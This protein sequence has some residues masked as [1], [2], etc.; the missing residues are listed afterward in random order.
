MY[1]LYGGPHGFMISTGVAEADEDHASTLLRFALHALQALQ[2]VR[3]P[4]PGRRAA[5]AGDRVALVPPASSP[6]ADQAWLCC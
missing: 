1:K 3:A 5:A 2:Q 4:L 6:A